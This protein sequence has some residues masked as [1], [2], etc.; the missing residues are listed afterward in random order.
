[1]ISF[2]LS[3]EEVDL[4]RS[5]NRFAADQMRPLARRCEEEGDVT[6]SLVREFRK[7][8][9]DQIGYPEA[10]GGIAVSASTAVVVEEEL[11]WGDAG[12]ASALPRWGAAATVIAAL[13][14]DREDPRVTALTRDD[15]AGGAMLAWTGCAAIR[16]GQGLVLDGT[17]IVPNATR[18]KALVVPCFFDDDVVLVW[19]SLTDPE[20]EVSLDSHQLGLRAAPLGALRLTSRRVATDDI[21]GRG[22]TARAALRLGL[23]RDLLLL[24]ARSVGTARAAFEYA[25]RYATQRTTFSRPIADHQAIAFMIAD[26]G[27][28]VDAARALLWDAAWA[29]DADDARRPLALMAVAGFVAE[30]MPGL[31][32]DA[33]QVLGGHGYIQDHP[34]EKWMRDARSLANY[35]AS[36]TNTLAALQAQPV[37]A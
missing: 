22:E 7:L 28:R 31:T 20:L 13:S 26:M 9:L 34:V 19:Q 37:S 5:S 15:D 16:D 1:M 4:Q 17:V 23:E 21:I 29:V 3:A 36:V 10:W 27:I 30:H 25:A 14:G 8:G 11:S 35:C 2:E 6:A 18:V 32:S 24:C 33:V 12:I